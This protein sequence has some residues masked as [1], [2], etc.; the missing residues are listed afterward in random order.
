MYRFDGLGTY[1][2][3]R[4][5]LRI[6]FLTNHAE[7]RYGLLLL[8]YSLKLALLVLLGS[9]INRYERTLSEIVILL[10]PIHPGQLRN[11]THVTI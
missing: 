5:A 3:G 10:N 1:V 7:S 8:L 4:E 6:Y 11:E 9:R 2:H